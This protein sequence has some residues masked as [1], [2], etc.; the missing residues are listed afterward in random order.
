MKFV[1]FAH[2]FPEDWHV[3][4]LLLLVSA[5]QRA[6]GR[7]DWS[8]ISHLIRE[9]NPTRDAELFTAAVCFKL[10][11]SVFYYLIAM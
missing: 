2:M 10:S 4:E 9:R 11:Y 8:S 3:Q 5:V 6:G 7:P 1:D